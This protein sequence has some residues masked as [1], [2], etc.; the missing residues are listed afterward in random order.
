LSNAVKFT[1][2]GGYAQVRLSRVASNAQVQVIDDGDGID[3]ELLPHIFDRFRQ[4]DSAKGR[5]HGGLGLGLAIVRELIHAHGGTVVAESPGKGRGSTFTVTM[6]IPAVVPSAIEEIR[7]VHSEEALIDGLRILVV[8]DD[9]D[10]RELIGLALQSLG[11]RV[12]LVPSAHE[13]LLS[14]GR[15]RPDVMI[16]DIGMPQ[17]DGYNLIR[18]IREMEHELSHTRLPAIALTAYASAADRD[19][20]LAAGYD[21]HL[22]KPAG[23]A[24]LTQALARFRKKRQQEA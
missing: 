14:I 11:A 9:L 18:R 19:Q 22:A 5:S 21:L 3:P 8:D 12:Q 15:D 13:A 16:A 24:D 2:R 23:P 10:A 6:P 1:P 20:A 17:E 7:L 4:G